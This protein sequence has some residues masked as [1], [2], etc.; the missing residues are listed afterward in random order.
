M[1][2]KPASLLLALTFAAAMPA[3]AQNVAIVNG[4][5]IPKSRADAL[6]KQVVASGQSADNKELQ[7]MVRENLIIREV[8]MQEAIKGGHDKRSDVLQA[9]EG[10]RH[11]IVVTA[12]MRNYA[13]KNKISDAAVKAEYDQAKSRMGDKEYHVRHIQVDTEAEAKDI[14]AKLKTGAKFEELAKKSKDQ[15]TANTGGELEWMNIADF[16][17]PFADAVTPLAKGAVAPNPIQTPG[18][19]HVLRLDDTRAAKLPSMEEVK[20][21]I[22]EALQQRQVL[23]FQDELIKKN[24]AAVKVAP[25]KIDLGVKQVVAQGKAK[26]SP[27]LREDIKRD[28]IG[29]EVLIM[30]ANKQGFGTR[31]EVAAALDNARQSIIIN[32]MLADYM[33]KNPVKEPEMRAE[34]EKYKA[35]LG[36]KEYKVRH[37]LVPTEDEA[38]GL[39]AKLRAG[40]KFED[41]AKA[42]SKDTNSAVKG[43]D[44]DWSNPGMWVPEF[45]KAMVALAKG[46]ITDAP[47]KTQ[48]GYHVIKLDDV[49]PLKLPP[50]ENV[51][52]QVEDQMQQRKLAMFRQQLREKATVK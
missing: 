25:S 9:L 47:V 42:S 40:S 38:K 39:I 28:L 12:L 18:G 10:A 41:L 35:T 24:G 29:R 1:T 3:F 52:Q 37:I 4:K 19:F 45:S 5:A 8:L 48:H 20:P 49:R 32:A 51:R 31:P 16:P 2:L 7:D 27:E 15:A 43:G 14:I 21:R 44:L 23:Q 36:D 34:Y 13:E 30:E 11:Q 22:V 6:V 33:K 26:D 50:F 46:A 17:K